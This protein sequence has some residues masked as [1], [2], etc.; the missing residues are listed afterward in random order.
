M[1]FLIKATALLVLSA[2][3]ACSIGTV[4]TA[5][6]VYTGGI[7]AVDVETNDVDLFVPVPLRLIDLG[8]TVADL[9]APEIE[10]DGDTQRTLNELRP[11]LTRL[12]DELGS[13]PEGEIVR[14]ED[15]DQLVVVRQAHG[16]LRVEVLSVEG[17]VRVS[18]PQ[19]GAARLTRR[20]LALASR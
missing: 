19:R 9:W 16:S 20:A 15:G 18:V 14:V 11:S 2:L 8:L 12:I 10:L 5:A 3:G 7:A 6:Y 13:L 1:M 4:C 17:R